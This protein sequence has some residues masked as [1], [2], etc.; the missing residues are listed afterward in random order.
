MSGKVIQTSKSSWRRNSKTLASFL[1]SFSFTNACITSPKSIYK[2]NEL[3]GVH[4]ISPNKKYL[5]QKLDLKNP[6]FH[7]FLVPTKEASAL[8]GIYCSDQK[9]ILDLTTKI[10]AVIPDAPKGM[11]I[12]LA[13]E[14]RNEK[15]L[16]LR[17]LVQKYYMTG[18]KNS[19]KYGREDRK[20][21]IFAGS[22]NSLP[23]R[24]YFVDPELQKLELSSLREITFNGLPSQDQTHLI[25]FFKS[26]I[27]TP[28]L[29]RPNK[30]SEE[31]SL[32]AREDNNQ[33]YIMGFRDLPV[34]VGKFD[35]DG[36]N[37]NNKDYFTTA[38]NHFG[39]FAG[40]LPA[41]LTEPDRHSAELTFPIK[42]AIPLEVPIFANHFSFLTP[43]WQ[44]Y[45]AA[46]AVGLDGSRFSWIDRRIRKNTEDFD[47]GFVV[48]E[49]FDLWAS[50]IKIFTQVKE[51]QTEDPQVIDFEVSLDLN[52]F[53]AYG[54]HTSEFVTK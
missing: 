40:N 4:L 6:V 42:T 48:N 53:C 44:W 18:W 7:Q 54:R 3:A 16:V 22:M 1:I 46:D 27:A 28:L 9:Q 20:S 34:Y 38:E 21:E 43:N 23:R 12:D 26:G 10:R 35:S 49:R 11:L 19:E 24:E 31:I 33:P 29:L 15:R 39:S 32:V 14:W 45:K 30:P 8:F 36:V 17:E 37:T 2:T 5:Q 13:A 47:F 51:A 41:T 25:T 50:Y 52:M